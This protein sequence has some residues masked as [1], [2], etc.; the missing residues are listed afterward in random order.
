MT[1]RDDS[2]ELQPFVEI[3]VSPVIFK[4]RFAKDSPRKTSSGYKEFKLYADDYP[5]VYILYSSE[6]KPQAYVGETSHLRR[7]MNDH[8]KN[9]KRRRLKRLLAIGCETFNKSATYNIESNLI[10]CMLADGKYVLQNRSQTSAEFTMH[11]YY[12]KRYYSEKLFRLIWSQLI[13]AG[14]AR[15]ALDRVQN[16]DVFKLSPFKQLSASQSELVRAALDFCENA[17]QDGISVLLIKGDAGTGKSV[18]LSTLF[19]ALED[20]SEDPGS[21]LFRAKNC[22]LVNHTEQLKTYRKIAKRIDGLRV[23]QFMKPTTFV[24]ESKKTG[25]TADVVVVDEAH[26]LLSRSDA[27]NNFKESNHLE[28]IVKRCRVA[29]VVYDDRQVLKLKSYWD[30]ARMK[31]IVEAADHHEEF[32]L[33]E[34]FRMQASREIVE[35]IDAF[36]GKKEV[37]PM[38]MMEQVDEENLF[39]FRFFETASEMYEAIRQKDADCSLSRM[40]ATFDYEHK[41]DGGTY[42]VHEGSFRL[43]WNVPDDNE[44]WA[45]RSET[46]GEVGSIYTVQGFD[47]NYAGVILGPSIGYDEGAD[48]IKVLPDKYKDTESFK[49]REGISADDLVGI[50]E[51]IILN[52]VNILMKRPIRGL[53][54]FASD[55]ALRKRLL[56]IQRQALDAR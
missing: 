34:Q 46:L 39:E 30:E 22:F 47:L 45:E 40:V 28:E 44:T 53:Y 48:R 7:R 21:A 51:R 29:I 32:E 5:T 12:G 55:E 8:L 2:K 13:E 17:P 24:N 36:V 14:I 3:T 4:D 26:L 42:Y 18:V 10:S 54:I 43:P 16:S 19:K 35:W 11:N 20:R 33:T 15:N 25:H 27:Y 38:P 23:G 50:K 41:K 52:S 6:K 31:A 56:T 37:L 1:Q 9:A 49:G